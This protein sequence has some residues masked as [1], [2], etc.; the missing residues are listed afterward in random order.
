MEQ[1]R[2]GDSKYRGYKM[3]GDITELDDKY[4]VLKW[5]DIKSA[6]SQQEGMD[7]AD[8]IVKVDSHRRLK[9]NKR[10]NKYVVLNLEDELDIDDLILNLILH[11]K[12]LKTPYISI[13]NIAVEIINGIIHAGN[14]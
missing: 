1:Y 11:K 10:V 14:P 8:L 13:D 2:K 6:L 12:D 4:C 7:F 9:L 3:K 5:V